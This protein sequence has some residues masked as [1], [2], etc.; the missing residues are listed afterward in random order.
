MHVCVSMLSPL[1]C[2][3]GDQNE[4]TEDTFLKNAGLSR[5]HTYAIRRRMDTLRTTMKI[6]RGRWNRE[7]R[8]GG[9]VPG[10]GSNGIA[11][12]PKVR[13]GTVIGVCGVCQEG[14]E[15]V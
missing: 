12:D 11:S 13:C 3:A 8:M 6:R 15:D 10:G 4:E 1:L 9:G 14:V 5:H 2:A 7:A